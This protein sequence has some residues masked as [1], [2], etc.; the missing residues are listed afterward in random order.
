VRERLRFRERDRFGDLKECRR[1]KRVVGIW[2]E[3]LGRSE[4]KSVEVRIGEGEERE[5]EERKEGKR[6]DGHC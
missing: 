2:R 3:E 6:E 4:F 5:E 1:R